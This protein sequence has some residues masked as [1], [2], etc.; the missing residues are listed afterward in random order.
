[1]N[2]NIMPK[3]APQTTNDPMLVADSRYLTPEELKE[4]GWD[5]D[6]FEEEEEEE[7]EEEK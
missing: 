3:R 6:A 5:E 1:M 2:D 4:I 7:E